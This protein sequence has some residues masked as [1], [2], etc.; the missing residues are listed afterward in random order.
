MPYIRRAAVI[1]AA[2]IPFLADAAPAFAQIRA[3]E[4][5]SVSQTLDGTAL[6]LTYSRP[7]VRGRKL[8]GALVPWGVVWTPGANWA[9]TLETN[10]DILIE[11]TAVPAGR[12]SVWMIPREDRWTVSL[13]PDPDLFHFQK[14][15]SSDQEIQFSVEPETAAHVEMLT[16]SFPAVTGD[17]AVVAMRWGTA[18]IPLRVVA[19]PTQAPALSDEARRPIVGRYDMSFAPGI[20]WP[21]E[22]VLEVVER[23]G[24]LR[25]RLPFS[26]H[27]GDELE[28]DLVPAGRDRFSPGLYRNGA[29][30]NIEMSITFEFQVDDGHRAAA[31]ILRGI[32]G[33]TF[34]EG[35]RAR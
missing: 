9:T 16:W 26:I 11:G 13:D 1:V 17:G 24:R 32:E 4:R 33:S 21:L 28:F 27:P 7:S 29:L 34:A 10:R 5:A 20:G 19:Q 30:F 12:Y 8:F 35:A 18:S 2:L 25:G 3:S 23:D 6:T 31:V 15:D 22:G 14:P